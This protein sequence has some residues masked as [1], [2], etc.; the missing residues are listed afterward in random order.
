[1]TEIEREYG[2]A[3]QK[4]ESGN[5]TATA[6]LREELTEDVANIKKAVDDLRS[7][8]PENWWDRHEKR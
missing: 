7:T 4:V 5:R 3:K 2:E 6:G 1:V 8:S